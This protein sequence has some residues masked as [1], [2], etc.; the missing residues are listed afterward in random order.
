MHFTFQAEEA[1]RER[2]RRQQ[3]ADGEVLLR[4]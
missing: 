4:T 2:L 1:E 3:I